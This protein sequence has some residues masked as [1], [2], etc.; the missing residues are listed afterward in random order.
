MKS[1]KQLSLDHWNERNAPDRTE[2]FDAIQARH[3]A[4]RDLACQ[5]LSEV[6]KLRFTSVYAAT[7]SD[8]FIKAQ[9]AAGI[10]PEEDTPN[11]KLGEEMGVSHWKLHMAAIS[12]H[13]DHASIKKR[14]EECVE[15]ICASMDVEQQSN[16]HAGYIAG[17]SQD[18]KRR[19]LGEEVPEAVTGLSNELCN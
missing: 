5:G 12:S 6:D 15:Q 14:Q 4:E 13:E 1:A 11:Y 16:F 18:F 17:Q 7:H 8:E 10:I 19:L 9:R 2:D 3:T